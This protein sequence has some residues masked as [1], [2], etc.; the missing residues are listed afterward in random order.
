MSDNNVIPPDNLEILGELNYPT[1]NAKI[2]NLII[3]VQ[4]WALSRDGN[5]VDI[6]IYVDDEMIDK[7]KTGIARLDVEKNFSNIKNSYESGFNYQLGVLKISNGNHSLKVIAK[8]KENEKLLGDVSFELHK[9]AK[10][11]SD[12]LAVHSNFKEHGL[13]FCNDLLIKWGGFQPSQRVLDVGCSMG[14][15]AMPL[16]KYLDNKGSYEGLDI[17]R[18]AIDWCSNNITPKYPNFCFKIADIYNKN[19]NPY[20]KLT[21]SEYKFPY[22]NGEFDFVCL[23]SVFTHM[24]PKDMENYFSEISRVLKKQGKCIITFFI[25]NDTHLKFEGDQTYAPFIYEKEGFRTINESIPEQAI[26]YEGEY[27]RKLYEKNDFEI[28]EPIKYGK[29][30]ET[31]TIFGGQDIILGR[32]KTNNYIKDDGMINS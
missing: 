22:Q 4:G 28:L 25:L 30:R 18:A 5:E 13:Q 1:P 20:G 6:L 8:N 17:V 2:K 16:M 29:W 14:R 24:L 31:N 3:N 32:K 15:L 7:T 19:Y 21:A 23:F 12:V 10:E 26:A 11:P 27:V 9:D